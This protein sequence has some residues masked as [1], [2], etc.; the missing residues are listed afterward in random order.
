[1]RRSTVGIESKVEGLV[2]TLD[3]VKA[4]VTK[5]AVVQEQVFLGGGQ[6]FVGGLKDGRKGRLAGV[7]ERLLTRAGEGALLVRLGK[8][9]GKLREAPK[10]PTKPKLTLRQRVERI[11]E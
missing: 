10:P 2:Q 7:T 3:M 11:K 5:T 4:K 8:E 9:E 1:M 6:I